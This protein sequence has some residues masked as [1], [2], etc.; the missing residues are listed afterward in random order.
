MKTSRARRANRVGNYAIRARRPR[1][2]QGSGNR[3]VRTSHRNP[4]DAQVTAFRGNASRGQPFEA[5]CLQHGHPC[6]R[7]RSFRG[8]PRDDC[9]FN[10]GI[11]AYGAKTLLGQLSGALGSI[12]RA[13]CA[14]ERTASFRETGTAKLVPTYRRPVRR[15]CF[16]VR[17]T[18]RRSSAVVWVPRAVGSFDVRVTG[19]RAARPRGIRSLEFLCDCA[20]N[21]VAAVKLESIGSMYGAHFIVRET[22][23]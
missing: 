5:E 16:T 22:G 1:L 9:G 7:L 2:A 23:Q 17:E 10:C 15:R 13:P 8:Q 18:G 3:A 12:A 11:S 21:R 14:K 19:C 4:L 6:V 20:G